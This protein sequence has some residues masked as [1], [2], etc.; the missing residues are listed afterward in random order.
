M[1]Y[2]QFQK[3]STNLH[4]VMPGAKKLL[5]LFYIRLRLEPYISLLEEM[6]DPLGTANP[7]NQCNFNILRLRTAKVPDPWKCSILF[8]KFADYFY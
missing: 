7:G 1:L 3:I 8:S 5:Q 6:N 4:A 2:F